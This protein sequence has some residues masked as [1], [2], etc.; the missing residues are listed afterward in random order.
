MIM[1]FDSG[2]E[3]GIYF[4][5]GLKRVLCFI[6]LI[7]YI[8]LDTTKVF[9]GIS[10][11]FITQSCRAISINIYNWVS[12]KGFAKIARISTVMIPGREKTVRTVS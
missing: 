2:E 10:S 4:F 11:H 5:F 8:P 7:F 9:L 1:T 12:T 3:I 6:N